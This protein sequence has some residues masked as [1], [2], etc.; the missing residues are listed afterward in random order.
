MD[1]LDTFLLGTM[2]PHWDQLATHIYS[3]L[4]EHLTRRALERGRDQTDTVSA[5]MSLAY[6]TPP[7][8]T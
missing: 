3:T 4:F 8:P 5:I 2:A 6:K 1:S 7:S